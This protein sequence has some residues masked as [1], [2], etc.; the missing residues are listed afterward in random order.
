MH[1]F[2]FVQSLNEDV[3]TLSPGHR[4]TILVEGLKPPGI[5]LSLE[6]ARQVAV[7]LLVLPAREVLQE[8]QVHLNGQHLNWGVQ[9]LV[10]F[11]LAVHRA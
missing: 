4:K 8:L 5:H 11:L 7:A 10:L 1:G 2:A 6:L 3:L 9:L